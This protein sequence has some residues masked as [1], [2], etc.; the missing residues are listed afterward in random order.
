MQIKLTNK[1]LLKVRGGSLSA[2]MLN[3]LA[4]G[5]GLLFEIGQAVGSAIR[6]A[7]TKTTC[8]L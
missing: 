3:A 4:K 6:R 2:T 5:A 7:I 1:Q 8:T